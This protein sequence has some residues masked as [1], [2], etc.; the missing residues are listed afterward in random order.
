MAAR[1][2]SYMRYVPCPESRIRAECVL[3]AQVV[4]AESWIVSDAAE[5]RMRWTAS[6]MRPERTSFPAENEAVSDVAEWAART[7]V[8]AIGAGAELQTTLTSA[9][10]W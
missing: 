6:R 9:G 7:R 3:N 1:H 8:E 10:A 2:T 5:C 4:P